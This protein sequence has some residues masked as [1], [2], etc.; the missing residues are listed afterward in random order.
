MKGIVIYS[1]YT[2]S[3]DST[4]VQ[5]FGR[6]ENGES[7]VSQHKTKPYFYVKK[8]DQ[9]KIK[10]YLSKYS[11]SDSNF[12]NFSSEEL[13]K[14]SANTFPE[15][16]KL[17]D[18]IKKQI[19]TYEAD[20]RPQYQFLY[21]NQIQGLI[22][23]E[24]PYDT[25]EKVDRVYTDPEIKT[26]TDKTPELK[27]AS[28]DTESDDKGNLY[29]IG[30]H[31][32]D[33][34]KTFM[35]T[36]Q[37][38]DKIINCEDEEDCLQKFKEKIIELDPDII[39]GWNVIDFDF[40]FLQDLFR[41]HKISFDLGRTNDQ[42]R[43]RIQSGFFR[44]SSIDIPGRQV[45]DA[46]SFIRDPFIKEAPSIKFANFPSYTLEDV[47]QAILGEG[48]ILKGKDRHKEIISLYEDKSKKSQEK[49]ASYNIKDCSLVYDILEKTKILDLSIERSLLTGLS[50]D[51]LTASIAAFDSLYL[52]ETRKRSL[53]APTNSFKK[54]ESRITGG[55]VNSTEP[56]I[57]HNVLVFDFKSLYPS[58]MRTFNID[59]SS[60][61]EKK[62]SG[63]I[64]SPNKAYFR[65][66]N[67]ILPEI[68]KDLHK[69]R[70]KAKK[71]SRELSSYA[72]K[73]IM[74]SF[75]GVLASPNCRFFNLKMA[76]S[77]THF[78]QFLIK[79]TAEEIEKKGF[80][81]IYSDTDS[82]F[83]ETNLGKD[84][85]N[86]LGSQIEKEINSFYDN[87]VKKNYSRSSDL[88]LEFEKQYI[89]LMIPK[90]R[91]DSEKAAKKRYA[92]LIE[93]KVDGKIEEK[94]EIVGLE[95]IR[96]DWTKAAQDFQKELLKKVFKSE[97]PQKFIKQYIEKLESGKLDSKLVYKKS[98]RKKLSDYTKTTPPHVKAARKLKSLD[99]N[100]I[101]YYITTDGP[102]PIQN[103]K[104]K[105]D[106][107]HYIDKQIKPIANQVLSLLDE[108]FDDVKRGSKQAKLF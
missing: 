76:N 27:L 43:L 72:I 6:L 45:I 92:G 101:K 90:V 87:Y 4:L 10:K 8:S 58:I 93:S 46:L 100:V 49:L 64:E 70:E 44:S 41:K 15:L 75:F 55:Y 33:F 71:E 85:A 52:K 73:I 97:S 51:R 11:V 21:D 48:K 77:I 98:I 105:I 62:E 31:T 80:K 28:I 88:E 54:K 99:S 36:D 67:G 18:H 89:S 14:I 25:A 20:V 34:S 16:N 42:L 5:L 79:L 53:A 104:H 63:S 1:T 59:P 26:I 106:Y 91:G 83:I 13:V 35:I 108:K 66:E 23:I 2:T 22:K 103:L 32:P 47:S 60:Y 3:G 29:C 30:I 37:K 82:V 81:T 69:A 57:Y 95:A 9:K 17:Y 74:N 7:F 40:K 50:I 56:G 68:L 12:K 24:G 84:K 86:S 102:E 19:E 65:N 38:S 96:G 61:L 107:E 39:T 78:G 94:I